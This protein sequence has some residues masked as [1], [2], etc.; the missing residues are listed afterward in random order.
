MKFSQINN[1]YTIDGVSEVLITFE[2]GDIFID[3][4]NNCKKIV[5]ANYNMVVFRNNSG[6]QSFEYLP[7]SESFITNYRYAGNHS[8]DILTIYEDSI[9]LCS[10]C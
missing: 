9:P 7:L 2:Y 6:V 8:D 1:D 10:N 3:S 5:L 4:N